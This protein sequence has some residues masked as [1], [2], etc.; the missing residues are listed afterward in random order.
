MF[1]DV[2]VPHRTGLPTEI[3]DF[4][5]AEDHIDEH[6]QPE[7]HRVV[8]AAGEALRGAQKPTDVEMLRPQPGH[9]DAMPFEPCGRLIVKELEARGVVDDPTAYP[10]K[11]P[12]DERPEGTESDDHHDHRDGER[13]QLWQEAL[14][15][16]L[17]RPH[18]GNDEE[19]ECNG[20]K[21]RTRQRQRNDG[22][23]RG[24]QNQGGVV[25]S[26]AHHGMVL[27][28][29]RVCTLE[30]ARLGQTPSSN[31]SRSKEDRLPISLLC[32]R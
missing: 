5:K 14:K 23:D 9:R 6:H 21:D 13:H 4:Q 24:D 12:D 7:A 18:D 28:S 25:K 30:L 32:A 2:A 3:V 17:Q 1:A 22:R 31:S 20:R 11:C 8:E 29:T 19:R 15:A 10:T 27:M 26:I 16:L